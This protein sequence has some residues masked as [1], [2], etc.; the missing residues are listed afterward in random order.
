MVA[1]G[2]LPP[3][4]LEIRVLGPVEIAW[5]GLPIDIGG[6][7]A[8]ALVARL[9]IDRRIIVSV[10]RLVDSLWRDND[11]MGA[12]I[13]MRS[14][15]SRLRKRIR[16]AGVPGDVIVTRAPGYLLD[17]PAETTDVLRLERLVAEG[18]VQL[19]RRNPSESVRLLSEAEEL[20]RG[21]AY[22]EVRDEPFARAE[23]RRLEEL[24]LLATETR[25][26]AE[27]SMGRHEAVTG[28]LETLTSANP[29]RERLWS[30]LMLALYRCGRQAEALRVFQG[31]RAVLV[32]EL[33]I[34]PGH[35]VSWLEHAVLAHDPALEFE[36]VPETGLS[37]GSGAS[38]PSSTFRY[39]VRLPASQREGPLV[40]RAHESGLLREWW[41][42]V[43]Q[44]AGRLLLVDG[45]PGI[46][47][48]RLVVDLARTVEAEGALVLW[49]RCDEDPVAP[50][51]P[52]AEGLGRYFQSLSAD[53]I[54][55]MPDWQLA[56]LSRLVLRLREYAPLAEDEG[57]DPE[58]ERFRFFEAVVATL[59]ELASRG[60][61]LVVIDNLH[62][63]DQ[64]TL[65]LLRHV[66]RGVDDGK[67]GVVG[68]FIDT[69]VPAAHRL[70]ATLAD[71]RAVHP[72]ATVHLR[73]L[74]SAGVEE[75]VQRWPK[76]PSDL[77][78]Q[79][80]RLTDGNP[81]F[82]DELLR[83]VGYREAEQTEEGDAPV[84]PDLSPTE[85]IRELV[86]RR[87][88]R[89]PEDVIYLLQAAAVAGPE[90]EAG[91]VAEA[92]EL[93]PERQLDAF[94][95]AEE[96]R[97]LRRVG[98]DIGDRY[99]FTHTLVRD[100]IYGELLRGRRLR[101]H[102][103]IAVATERVHADQLDTYVNELAHHFSMSAALADADKATRYCRAAGER[104]LRLLAF[105]EAAE[106]FTRSLEVAEQFGS[107]PPEMRC[108][109]LIALAEAQNR[110]G[111]TASANIN[112]ER[113]ATLA[114]SL[115]DADRLA[116]AAL[117]AGPLSYLGI[118]RANDEQIRLLEEALAALPEGKDSHLR[119][120]VTARLGLV[121]VYRAD[122]P[123]VGSLRRSLDL[124]TAAVAM[125]R[126]LGDRVALGYAL[127]ARMHALWGVG[128]APERLAT[129]TELGEIA[130]DIGDELL[131]LHGHMWRIRELLAQGD[132]DVA[133]DEI[134]RFRARD[135]GPV[136]PV[137]ASYAFNAAAMMA[138]LAG[139]FETAE[140]LGQQALEAAEGHNEL[141]LSF[142]GALMLWTWW[143]RGDLTGP[144]PMFREVV[145]QTPTE[146]HTVPAALALVRAEAGDTEASLR[147]LR[148]MAELGWQN[149]ADDQSEGVSLA[150]AAAACGAL[151]AS[152]SDLAAPLYDALRPYAGTA[153]VVRAPAAACVGPADHY[154]GL[155][156]GVMGD[157]PLAEVHHEAALRLARRMGS[158]PFVAAA[159]V[160]LARILRLRRPTGDEERVAMLLRSAEESA[161][162]MGLHRL[163]RLAADPG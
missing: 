161:L 35:D 87:V 142:Y 70:R 89:L 18:R 153:I 30:Q 74:S 50:F 104:A 128:N 7:K 140:Q 152:A 85:A 94:D 78:P 120:M 146:Y 107:S 105:E 13:A 98:Q 134:A 28:E 44:G 136:H 48:T 137:E 58:R 14:T 36:A 97:L 110:A 154:L 109:V 106:H 145:A 117:R 51:Q 11:G 22:S 124:S 69:E 147:H 84:P 41:T 3:Q 8:R 76:V 64:P 9:L 148:S 23:A 72:V 101:Y 151:G 43:G 127:N 60:P 121:I 59:N 126:R 5:D 1:E 144:A 157:L 91:V 71:F 6:V 133:N 33:G 68:M 162:A 31:L 100:A 143:Q 25:M 139:E 17:V 96:S 150:V 90:C 61:V 159:E 88:S 77:V 52:F 111:D 67:L 21:S 99:A 29:L 155:L 108:D 66:L 15:I 83:Q 16:E 130:D 112:L 118:V 135:T 42:S 129:G 93:T 158:P 10:D 65:L 79:L 115:G 122:V 73:G 55:H 75:T 46:G 149:V 82:L 20:W 138:L 54:S 119:A 56:E 123:A 113:A 37:P 125:A 38:S 27:L 160:E 86:A 2:E 163:A 40:G 80:C 53:R 39:Q 102:H 19:A 34:E 12:E 49:G 24:R 47:K 141:A 114:R 57:G 62:A 95:R 81:L 92:A 32:D 63:A 103:R 45:D 26:D 131:A 4:R 156:A 132:V 116:A